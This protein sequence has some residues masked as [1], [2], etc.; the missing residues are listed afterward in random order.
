LQRQSPRVKR[1]VRGI[2][3]SIVDHCITHRETLIPLCDVE[4][5]ITWS[6]FRFDESSSHRFKSLTFASRRSRKCRRFDWPTISEFSALLN[7]KQIRR[8]FHV[9]SGDISLWDQAIFEICECL[10]SCPRSH[11]IPGR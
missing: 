6:L 3:I 2:S 10:T 8:Y 11:V 5:C 4:I 9:G 1:S 7:R